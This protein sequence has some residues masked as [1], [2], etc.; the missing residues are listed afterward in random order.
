VAALARDLGEP[1]HE[2][3]ADPEDVEVH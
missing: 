1:A 2:G 3:A